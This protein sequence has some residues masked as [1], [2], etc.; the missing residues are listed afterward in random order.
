M[1]KK[2]DKVDVVVVGTGWAGGVV[3]A[4]RSMPGYKVVD[5][6]RGED[7]STS[8]NVGAKDE[9]RYITRKEMMQDLQK[10]TVT[11]RVN[12]DETALPVRTQNE[13]MVGTDVGGGSVHWAG[14]TY[15]FSPLDYEIRSKT[16]EKY[17]EDKI[18]EGMLLEDWGINYKEMEEHYDRDRK[19]VV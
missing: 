11:S 9:L 6:E 17:G 18:P 13:M 7:I 4:E 19:S 12:L 1:P 10:E 14:A 16:I 3:I 2:L 15:R 8:D 5:I